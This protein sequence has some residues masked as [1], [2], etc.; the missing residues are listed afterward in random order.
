MTVF[1]II[2]AAITAAMT[3]ALDGLDLEVAWAYLRVGNIPMPTA[4]VLIGAFT[5]GWA[6]DS[7]INKGKASNQEAGHE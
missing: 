6:A 4:H 2:G 1:V 3:G 7:G 5:L